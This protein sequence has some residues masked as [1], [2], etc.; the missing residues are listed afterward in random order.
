MILVWGVKGLLCC[1]FFFSS[2]R[3][4]TRCLSDWSSDVCSSDLKLVSF[5]LMTGGEEAGYEWWIHQTGTDS[6]TYRDGNI[7]VIGVMFHRPFNEQIW[8]NLDRHYNYVYDRPILIPSEIGI[9]R[10]VEYFQQ[11]AIETIGRGA[12]GY[13]V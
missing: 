1:F 4:H 12:Q 6:A 5:N 8:A 13:A 7:D 11:S 2:R 9:D 3:R 10:T